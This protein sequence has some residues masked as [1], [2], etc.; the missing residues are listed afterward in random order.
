MD[1]LNNF[2][3]NKYHTRVGIHPDQGMNEVKE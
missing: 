2:M 1:A 3:N